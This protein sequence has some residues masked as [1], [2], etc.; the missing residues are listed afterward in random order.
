MSNEKIA[1]RI[2]CGLTGEEYRIGTTGSKEKVAVHLAAVGSVTWTDYSVTVQNV[3]AGTSATYTLNA[4]G[5]CTFEIPMGNIYEVAY[6]VIG[7]YVQP[8]AQRYTASLSARS[9]DYTY[10]NAPVSYEQ[11]TVLFVTTAA[12]QTVSVLEGLSVSCQQNG[13]ERWAGTIHNG[14]AN[15]SIPYG[16]TYTVVYPSLSGWVHDHI[17]ESYTAGVVSRD[18]SVH[19]TYVDEGVFGYD[20]A[21]TRYTLSQ[22]EAGIASGTLSANDIIA[23]AF[24][25]A[26]LEAAPRGDGTYGCGFMWKITG[27]TTNGQWASSN[28]KF[29]TT[30]LPFR[31]NDTQARADMAGSLNTTY[32]QQICEE[33]SPALTSSMCSNARAMT[34]T[35]GGV[36]RTGFVPAFGQIKRLCENKTLMQY[37]YTILG[38]TCPTIWSGYWWTSCQYSASLAVY[39]YNGG[40][41][42]DYK[43]YSYSVLVAFDL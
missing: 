16:Q 3:S 4:Q 9:L 11:L 10:S 28:V 7:I 21:G 2:K 8:T 38:K 27:G 15:V 42:N 20:T 30:R 22:I 19:Y 24:T 14:I 1:T 5:E 6:P 41:F 31:A 13:V 36:A 39:L 25:D 37:L 12:S 26:E 17:G 32:I 40:F 23:G 35:I 18:I 33:F 34:L 43:R 29:D